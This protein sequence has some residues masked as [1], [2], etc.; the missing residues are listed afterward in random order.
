M[1]QGGLL[2]WECGRVEWIVEEV[3]LAR[4]SVQKQVE[5]QALRKLIAASNI[6]GRVTDRAALPR[7]SNVSR[8]RA[9]MSRNPQSPQQ[10]GSCGVVASFQGG[11]SNKFSSAPTAP[12]RSQG[13]LDGPSGLQG[14]PAAS[15]SGSPAPSPSMA[16]GGRHQ[17]GIV[18][19]SQLKIPGLNGSGIEEAFNLLAC[20][21]DRIEV[22]MESE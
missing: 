3:K 12:C 15:K 18:G 7:A 10:R 14:C 21:L 1:V 20:H 2:G 17:E 16:G 6:P 5:A 13:D 9:P 11:G 8:L 19:G 22:F 4:A